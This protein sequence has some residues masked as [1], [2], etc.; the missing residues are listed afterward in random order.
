L[1]QARQAILELRDSMVN[2]GSEAYSRC[3][4]LREDR[5]ERDKTFEEIVLDTWEVMY[6]KEQPYE[7]RGFAKTTS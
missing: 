1:D 4:G 6:D 7:V 5:C 3:F 2:C